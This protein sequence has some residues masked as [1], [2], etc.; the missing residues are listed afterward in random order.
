M[1]IVPDSQGALGQAPEAAGA[2]TAIASASPQRSVFQS[3]LLGVA[4]GVS[5]WLVTKFLDRTFCRRK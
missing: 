5:V 4:T 2:V 1:A 3:I